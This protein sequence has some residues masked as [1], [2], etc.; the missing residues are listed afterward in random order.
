MCEAFP[1]DLIKDIRVMNIKKN[2]KASNIV[3]FKTVPAI[4]VKRIQFG[5]SNGNKP[6][7]AAAGKKD[8]AGF[9]DALLPIIKPREF[10]PSQQQQQQQQKKRKG[11]E[12][13]E[14]NPFA[15]PKKRPYSKTAAAS[16]KKGKKEKK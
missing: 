15:R 2:S 11:D 8:M 1:S 14:I 3:K 9:A 5:G 16:E 6:I 10:D 7:N 12:E 4:P 13:A